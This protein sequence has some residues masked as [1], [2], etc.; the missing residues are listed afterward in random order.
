QSEEIDA[1]FAVF[2]LPGGPV[3]G[4]FYP[5][6][7]S[8]L[9]RIVTTPAAFVDRMLG[10]SMTDKNSRQFGIESTS[11][12]TTW[13]CEDGEYRVDFFTLKDKPYVEV[14]E[15][16]DA[17]RVAE[18]K[19]N[20]ARPSMPPPAPPFDIKA[21]ER[22]RAK[23]KAM[24][25][26]VCNALGEAVVSG[27]AE[28]LAD[29]TNEKSRFAFGFYNPFTKATM[30]ESDGDGPAAAQPWVDY[31]RETLGAPNSFTCDNQMLKLDLGRSDRT[32]FAF[33][34][35]W[36]DAILSV[37]MRYATR[38]KLLKARSEAIEAG[39]VEP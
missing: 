26:K 1:V 19:A 3:A 34:G 31:V 36:Q 28:G 14:A 29:F 25:A 21:F 17:E 33:F 13:Q 23:Q 5:E 15:F 4:G 7:L 6:S 11:H 32:G 8:G 20:I 9:P 38:E 16:A 30:V 39:L 2:A 22:N 24:D 10:C 35:S 12:R 27:S 18:L 37:D